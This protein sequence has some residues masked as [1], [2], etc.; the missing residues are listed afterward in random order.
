MS[1]GTIDHDNAHGE[2]AVSVANKQVQHVVNE[3]QLADAVRAVLGQSRFSSANVSLAVVDDSTIHELNRRYLNHD[4]STD[5]LSFTL[6]E[7]DDRLEGEV[8][9]SADTAAEAAAEAG[10]APAAEQLLYA[11]HGTLHL[12]GYRDKTA[13]E[14][15]SMRAAEAALLRQFG[16]EPPQDIARGSAD[17]SRT[18]PRSDRGAKA[19]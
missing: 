2:F 12:V 4:W 11:V 15:Q 9:I 13:A 19:Q 8:I 10:W 7:A 14:A 16:F 5:V 6:E 17:E 1:H 18:S 3:G